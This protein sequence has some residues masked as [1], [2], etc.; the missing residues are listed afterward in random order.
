MP[1]SSATGIARLGK[2][3]PSSTPSTVS[4][5][6]VSDSRRNSLSRASNG[7]ATPAS[8]GRTVGATKEA[9]AGQQFSNGSPTDLQQIVVLGICYLPRR[10]LLPDRDGKGG[11]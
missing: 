1:R 9:R 3:G 8:S 4:G 11:R 5:G 10:A 6:V 7:D 2:A